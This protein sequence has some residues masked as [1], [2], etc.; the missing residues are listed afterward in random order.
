MDI[1]KDFENLVITDNNKKISKSKNK[2]Q[3][4]KTTNINTNTNNNQLINNNGK[5]YWYLFDISGNKKLMNIDWTTNTIIVNDSKECSFSLFRY[6]KNFTYETSLEDF[7]NVLITSELYDTKAYNCNN[8]FMNDKGKL[9]DYSMIYYFNKIVYKEIFNYLDDL[10]LF[11]P[12]DFIISIILEEDNN[13]FV[14]MINKNINI[15][16]YLKPN[17]TKLET[18]DFLMFPYILRGIR[19]H[20]D[21]QGRYLAASYN[22]FNSL[23]NYMK[24]KRENTKNMEN[25]ETQKNIQK[26]PKTEKNT[27][28]IHKNMFSLTKKKDKTK[29][30]QT[31]QLNIYNINGSISNI[32]VLHLCEMFKCLAKG[33]PDL[34]VVWRS[35]RIIYE[36]DQNYVKYKEEND[37]NNQERNTRKKL[38]NE[39]EL[40]MNNILNSLNEK[41]RISKEQGKKGFAKSHLVKYSDKKTKTSNINK[42][43]SKNNKINKTS[44]IILD[45]PKEVKNNPNKLLDHYNNNKDKSTCSKITKYFNEHFKLVCGSKYNHYVNPSTFYSS[46]DFNLLSNT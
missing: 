12:E 13:Y 37:Y 3:N 2:K 38:D 41:L 15:T 14:A 4:I 16:K 29:T 21:I 8:I 40:Q 43:L 1:S 9:N 10:T 34:Q 42:T 44:N 33:L 30:D 6:Y 23:A 25:T 20:V 17:T 36:K 5:I 46:N 7:Q 24:Q 28:S 32:K 22:L 18:Q 39:Y 11:N 26:Q 45:K 35:N 27:F 19:K 31:I